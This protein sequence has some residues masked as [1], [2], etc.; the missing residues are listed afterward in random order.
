MNERRISATGGPEPVQDQVIASLAAA[1]DDADE[2][3]GGTES[4]E[5][6]FDLSIPEP[7]A[8]DLR[9]LWKLAHKKPDPQILAALG[10]NVPIL[11]SHSVTAF[12]VGAGRP[13]RVWGIRYESSL[14]GVDARTVSLQP[15]TELL[16]IVKVGADAELEIGLGG[17]LTVPGG[18]ASVVSEMPG[19]TLNDARVGATAKDRRSFE[20]RFT[21]VGSEGHRRRRPHVGARW[22]LYAQDRRLDGHQALLQ[23][24]LVPKGTRRVRVD[25]VSS[26]GGS[27]VVRAASVELRDGVVRAGPRRRLRRRRAPGC[28]ESSGLPGLAGRN[29]GDHDPD[30]FRMRGPRRR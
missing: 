19:V 3:R 21:P 18:V 2:E 8:L 24:L 17:E 5:A 6:P 11:F 29:V 28:R 13:P 23:T 20:I 22:Q 7:R 26:V 30:G 9:E 16:D 14:F 25:I 4:S 12:P 10:P 15:V 27:R 1:L